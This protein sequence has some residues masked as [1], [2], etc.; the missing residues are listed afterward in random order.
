VITK[1]WLLQPLA[2]ARVGGSPNPLQSFHWGGKDLRPGGSG[3]TQLVPSESFAV[4]PDDGVMQP[5]GDG[6]G[7][8]RFKD[9]DRIRPVCPFFE[10]HGE[11]GSGSGAITE[12]MVRE[13]G[14]E[15]RWCIR[16]ANLK[17]FHFTKSVGDRIEAVVDLPV[18]DHHLHVLSGRSPSGSA[19]PLI[20][21]GK[22]IPMGRLQAIRPTG[23]FPEIRIRFYP[24]EGNVYGP[25]DL[26]ER[27]AHVI[28]LP[29]TVPNIELPPII[30]Q[31]FS[32]EEWKGFA[33][34][35]EN[36]FLNSAAAW[37]AFGLVQLTDLLKGLPSLV[38]QIRQIFAHAIPG[39]RSELVRM[40][41]GPEADVKTLPPGM[42][43]FA[44]TLLAESGTKAGASSV[45]LVD[46]TG[47]GI[48]TCT[49]VKQNAPPLTAHARVVVCPPML[50]PDRRHPVSIA[51]GLKDR[52]D[53]DEVRA[54]PFFEQ[55][56][57]GKDGPVAAAVYDLFTRA[58]ET[59]GLSNLD[60]WNEYFR[61]ENAARA[62][63]PASPLSPWEAANKLWRLDMLPTVSD[64]PLTSLARQLH[65]RLS[66]REVLDDLFRDQ[67]GAI[68]RF[69]RR[70]STLEQ[71]YDQR[72]P[73]LTRG[74]D[75][76]PLHLTQRQYEILTGWA[77]R[78]K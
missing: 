75:R 68:Q 69:V 74:A 66:V 52:Q 12:P 70:P 50:A 60:V 38:S 42:F 4:N 51:D 64:L 48:I 36:C 44:S 3:K 9:G 23:A 5:A 59:A 45:G 39:E 18:K 73:A 43:A 24:P 25:H 31:F 49:L 57:A 55:N 78:L 54:E 62:A 53:R 30:K 16:H 37:P 32:N 7:E 33:L 14:Y 34:P 2:F 65:R 22:S 13:L 47:D 61:Q 28:A 41:L 63:Q 6:T 77:Q 10:L 20:P 67:P 26:A 58:F 17:P 27:I 40:I 1:I 76:Q 56:N 29:T 8:I 71:L 11:W 21:A 46:D 35:A 15:V 72:M 19:N